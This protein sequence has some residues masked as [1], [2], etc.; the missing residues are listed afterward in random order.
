[1]IIC[2]VMQSGKAFVFTSKCKI[3]PGTN[4]M[5]NTVF[6]DSYGVVTRCFAITKAEEESEL[7]ERYLSARGAYLPLKEIIGVFVPMKWVE[8]KRREHED[9]VG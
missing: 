3:K 9:K 2:E 6:G 5:V 7:F 8:A 1:M 4:V